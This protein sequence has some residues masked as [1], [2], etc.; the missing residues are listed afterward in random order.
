MDRVFG[1]LILPKTNMKECTKK[2]KEME[3]EY[4]N[5]ETEIFIQDSLKMISDKGMGEWN[6]SQEKYTLGS[7]RMAYRTD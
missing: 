7:G 5:G 3:K 2:V 6:G 4:I 1:G